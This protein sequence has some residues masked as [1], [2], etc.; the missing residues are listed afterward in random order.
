MSKIGL[1]IFSVFSL[2]FILYGAKNAVDFHTIREFSPSRG[3]HNTY[4]ILHHDHDRYTLIYKMVRKIPV[5]IPLHALEYNDNDTF[6][7]TTPE[8]TRKTSWNRLKQY[9]CSTELQPG[10]NRRI[11][12]GILYH[13]HMEQNRLELRMY[14]EQLRT[15]LSFPIIVTHALQFRTGRALI[16]GEL[17][18]DLNVP[19]GKETVF[20]KAYSYTPF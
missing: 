6:I 18:K 4:Y 13:N 11:F 15:I 10:K 20:I 9:L 17:R 3:S 14:N 7:I 12:M 16:L 1:T 5:H 19:G 2:C 8:R